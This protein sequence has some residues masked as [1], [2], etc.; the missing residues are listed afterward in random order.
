V[1]STVIIE[2]EK[3]TGFKHKQDIF[4]KKKERGDDETKGEK[5]V[6]TLHLFYIQSEVPKSGEKLDTGAAHP[7]CSFVLQTFWNFLVDGK[8]IVTGQSH[9]VDSLTV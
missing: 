9:H 3:K 5:A 6:A 4:I 8:H 7:F 2:T 1:A